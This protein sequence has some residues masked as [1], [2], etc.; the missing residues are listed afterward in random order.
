MVVRRFAPLSVAKVAGALYALIGV[1]IG[2][3]VALAALAGGFGSDENAGFMGSLF[4]VGAIVAFP[5]LYGCFGFV[6]TL[7][8]AWL[9]NIV[10]GMVGGIEIEVA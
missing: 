5:L 1:I 4:G 6:F 7:L 10:A 3:I 9:Y 8:A 2:A